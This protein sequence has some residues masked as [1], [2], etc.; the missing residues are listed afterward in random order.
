M[1]SSTHTRAASQPPKTK[2]SKRTCNGTAAPLFAI[3][4]SG[5]RCALLLAAL[6]SIYGLLPANSVGYPFELLSGLCGVSDK[7]YGATAGQVRNPCDVYADVPT[8]CGGTTG[9]AD[10]PLVFFF[11]GTADNTTRFIGPPYFTSG[12]EEAS[13]SLHADGTMIGIYVQGVSHGL[14][15]GWNMGN[16]GG[17]TD[18]MAFV[19]AI[20]TSMQYHGH[21]GRRYAVGISN[22][23]QFAQKVVVNSGMNFSGAVATIAALPIV[24]ASAGPAPYTYLYP[25][26]GTGSRKVAV[27]LLQ[28]SADQLLNVHGNPVP[29][30]PNAAFGQGYAKVPTT[31]SSG[32]DSAYLWADVNGCR[33]PTKT[34]GVAVTYKY[35]EEG[36]TLLTTAT[37]LQFDCAPQFATRYVEVKCMG[38]QVPMTVAGQTWA[39]YSLSF[40][41]TVETACAASGNCGT[42]APLYAPA[43]ATSWPAYTGSAFG[44]TIAGQSTKPFCKDTFAVNVDS[45]PAPTQASMCTTNCAFQAESLFASRLNAYQPPPQSPPPLPPT[46][47]PPPLPPPPSIYKI[48]ASFTLSGTLADYED[49]ETR[50]AIK[51]AVAMAANV[52]TSAVNL[53]FSA[54]SVLVTA[55]IYVGSQAEADAKSAALKEGLLS[56]PEVLSASLKTEYS[57][58]GLVE[59]VV[60]AIN[61]GG[62]TND[63]SLSPAAINGII[64]GVV[65]GVLALVAVGV[66]I[67]FLKMK[68][69]QASATTA[70]KMAEIEITASQES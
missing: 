14:N 11:H 57:S 8:A 35:A 4:V 62:S 67:Y 47:S 55:V 29:H 68:K 39:A 3:M 30:N 22:G 37:K 60:E 46:Q 59:P 23:A 21:I 70:V 43:T 41:K 50:M 44:V 53:T 28:G 16:T 20:V 51:S 5:T 38:H 69:S 65:L 17:T 45:E 42:S 48:T 49:P 66:G 34:D 33:A 13:T 12:A 24:P 18:D 52:S 36:S 15:L 27:M 6:P 2:K 7:N 31:Q 26:Q 32:I 58:A 9:K 19:Q 56:S 40:L 10:C 64:G 25:S 63:G 54:G 1:N 61:S